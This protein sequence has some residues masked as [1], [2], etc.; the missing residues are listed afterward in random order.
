MGLLVAPG[1]VDPAGYYITMDRILRGVQ[2]FLEY[3]MVFGAAFLIARLNVPLSWLLALLAIAMVVRSGVVLAQRYQVQLH[4]GLEW[5]KPSSKVPQP[6]VFQSSDDFECWLLDPRD[7]TYEEWGED[8]L[9]K[10]AKQKALQDPTI[11]HHHVWAQPTPGVGY[12]WEQDRIVHVTHYHT[13]QRAR[14]FTEREMMSIRDLREHHLERVRRE[15]LEQALVRMAKA[16]DESRIDMDW[17]LTPASAVILH[18]PSCPED[19]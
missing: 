15:Q 5:T 18:K 2:Q 17:Q 3:G 9:R 11:S 8:Q 14:T 19:L 4:L 6:V 12:R 16:M 13:E 10:A 1:V 7:W